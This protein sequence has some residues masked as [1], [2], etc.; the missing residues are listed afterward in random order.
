MSIFDKEA[1]IYDDWYK[2][3]LGAF[4]DEVET[5]CILNMLDLS[6]GSKI[7]DVGCGS[8]N[9][10]IKLAELGYEVTGVDMSKEML[11]KAKGKAEKGN[12]KIDF[13]EM[14]VYELDFDD[15]NFDA[16]FSI[17]AFEFI[18]DIQKAMDEVMRVLKK[19]GQMIIGM[20]N[21]DSSWGK[22]YMS[23]EY[24]AHSVFKYAKLKTIEEMKAY[25]PES[26]VDSDQCLFIAPETKEDKISLEEE[27]RLKGEG[28]EGGFICL[29]W[30]KL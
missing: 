1:M 11:K 25:Y 19:S 10:S 2:T 23:S 20:V 27:N 4:V 15:E 17:T 5:T 26:Y 8:G 30:I 6:K 12:L 7:L 22:L 24:Q 28:V 13:R 14:N 29:K 3:K 18:P 21:R 9:Y 16:V